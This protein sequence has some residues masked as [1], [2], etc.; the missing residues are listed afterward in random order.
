MSFDICIFI[1]YY[2]SF[3]FCTGIQERTQKRSHE[4]SWYKWSKIIWY[5]RMF[6]VCKT[7]MSINVGLY[8]VSTIFSRFMNNYIQYWIY[9]K[10]HWDILQVNIV[11]ENVDVKMFEDTKVVIRSRKSRSTDNTMSKRQSMI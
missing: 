4:V 1:A 3:I 10:S 8:E 7:I 6:Q 2:W 11:R 5:A 9:Q